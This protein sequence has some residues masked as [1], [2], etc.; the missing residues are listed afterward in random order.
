MNTPRK[1]LKG[2]TRE[3]FS[4]V[5]VARSAEIRTK[6]SLMW[7]ISTFQELS[8]MIV[9]NVTKNLTPRTSGPSIARW[10]TPTSS[11][12]ENPHEKNLATH[13]LYIFSVCYLDENTESLP[14]DASK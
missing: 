7:K 5:C 12:S 10:C 3:S 13:S 6:L 8:S 2:K 14:F 11:Q 9:T 4:A 1:S